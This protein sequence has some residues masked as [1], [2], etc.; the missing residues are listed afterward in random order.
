MVDFVLRMTNAQI[1]QYVQMKDVHANKD[2]Y[3]SILVVI[4][5]SNFISKI[6]HMDLLKNSESSN[7]DLHNEASYVLN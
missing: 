6:S 5:V 2:S 4:K 3:S 7:I 1:P